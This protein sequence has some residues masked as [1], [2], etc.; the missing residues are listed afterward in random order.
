MLDGLKSQFA[1]A[2]AKGLVTGS[3]ITNIPATIA[4]STPEQEIAAVQQMVRQGVNAIIM[5]PIAGA[6]VVPAID[7]AGKAGVPVI[8]TDIPLPQTKYGVVVWSQN[9]YQA[10]AGHAR[11]DPEGQRPDRPRPRRQPER[12]RPLRPEDRPT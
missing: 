5:E 1:K 10:D 11:A 4:A 8:L 9:Q 6:P 2:K 3:L 12:R 7:A